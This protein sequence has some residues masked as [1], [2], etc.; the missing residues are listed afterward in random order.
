MG[1][2]ELDRLGKGMEALK[3]DIRQ[4]FTMTRLRAIEVGLKNFEKGLLASYK[5]QKLEKF[6][7][8]VVKEAH[9]YYTTV[10][11]KIEWISKTWYPSESKDPETDKMI[12]YE[13][14]FYA[15]NH[16]YSWLKRRSVRP[17]YNLEALLT[18]LKTSRSAMKEWFATPAKST[19]AVMSF[20]EGASEVEVET[21]AD[22]EAAAEAEAHAEAEAEEEGDADADQEGEADADQETE[23]EADADQ[24]QE[25]ESEADAEQEAETET[26][27]QSLLERASAGAGTMAASR[28]QAGADAIAAAEMAALFESESGEADATLAALV[29]TV[30]EENSA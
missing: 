30:L 10:P 3:V 17:F 16:A 20:V 25:Q 6:F 12:Q 27:T 13:K 18:K 4:L 8:K 23:G 14:D 9:A 5:F 29:D 21:E 15:L 26:E 1:E 24:E 7:P 19:L 22:A 2:K 11:N 28:A